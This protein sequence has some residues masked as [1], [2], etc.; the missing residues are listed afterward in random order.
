MTGSQPGDPCLPSTDKDEV[1]GSSPLRPTQVTGRRDL[2][3]EEGLDVRDTHAAK[4]LPAEPWFEVGAM[5]ETCGWPGGVY[6]PGDR[7]EV[8]KQ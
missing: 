5:L 1:G 6:L 2:P 8:L 3:V 7:V 4:W